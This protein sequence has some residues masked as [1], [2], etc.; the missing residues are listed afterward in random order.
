MNC[1]TVQ[2]QM[3]PSEDNPSG[4]VTINESD[5][6]AET[7]TLWEAPVVPVVP[8]VPVAAPWAK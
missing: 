7:M 3:E 2:I 8:V 5:F 4:V 6:D 1:P